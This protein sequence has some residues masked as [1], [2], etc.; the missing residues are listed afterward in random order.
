MVVPAR[1]KGCE[2]SE[3]FRLLGEPHML[4]IV[5][6]AVRQAGAVRFKDFQK[7]L[8]LSPNTLTERLKRLVD[9]GLLSRQ[10]FQ[11]IPPR[12]EYTATTKAHELWPVFE[13]LEA[14]SAR[15]ALATSAAPP[16]AAG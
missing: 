7:E 13:T 15:H 2:L 9:A 10:A 3:L 6:H 14:W 4:G 12:V 16:S 1:T 11:E 8:A 5:H